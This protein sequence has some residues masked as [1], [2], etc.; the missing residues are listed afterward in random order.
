[1]V[2]ATGDMTIGSPNDPYNIGSGELPS[3]I[4]SSGIGTPQLGQTGYSSESIDD[5]INTVASGNTSPLGQIFGGLMGVGQSVLS[6][7]DAL[8]GIAGGLLTKEAYDR[9]SGIGEQAKREAMGIAERGQMES[10]FRPFTVTTPTGAM[11]TTR[12]GGQPRDCQ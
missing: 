11:F 2:V 5:L 6:S 7:P 12:M 4:F 8:T 9:L 3:G 10:E 1:M